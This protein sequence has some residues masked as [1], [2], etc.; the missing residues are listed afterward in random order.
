MAGKILVASQSFVLWEGGR[1]VRFRRNR[2]TIREGHPF[3]V[4][5]EQRFKPL[6]VDFD[7]DLTPRVSAST[8]PPLAN[9]AGSGEGDTFAC[10]SCDFE[11]KSAIGLSSHIRSKH[12]A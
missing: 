3:Q 6:K 2:T 4:A 11:A 10:P 1:M 8:A 12:P 9:S 7:V 5:N